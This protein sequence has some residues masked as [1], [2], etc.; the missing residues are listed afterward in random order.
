MAHQHHVIQAKNNQQLI[1]GMTPGCSNTAQSQLRSSS[2][3][4]LN[5]FHV[6]QLAQHLP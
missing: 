1:K 3:N 5:L 6:I 4:K 2:K